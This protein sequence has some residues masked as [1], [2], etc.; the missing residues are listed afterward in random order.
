MLEQAVCYDEGEMRSVKKL[1]QPDNRQEL[2]ERLPREL[3]REF[4]EGVWLQFA[5]IKKRIR[6]PVDPDQ[7]H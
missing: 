7:P 4:K 6:G 2:W 5:S 3:K 1:I